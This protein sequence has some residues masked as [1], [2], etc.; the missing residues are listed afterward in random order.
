[1]TAVGRLGEVANGGFGAF[2]FAKPELGQMTGLEKA[3]RPLGAR[4]MHSQDGNAAVRLGPRLN[5]RL[6]TAA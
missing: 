2:R 1:M 3:D 4:S 6:A 5:G